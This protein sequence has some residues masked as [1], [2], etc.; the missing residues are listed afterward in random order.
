MF[1]YDIFSF[2]TTIISV[3]D[4]SNGNKQT[5]A[6]EEE[7]H[8]KST[9]QSNSAFISCSQLPSIVQHLFPLLSRSVIA[10]I[11]SELIVIGLGGVLDK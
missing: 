8:R 11:S 5:T 2:F 10:L 9:I 7:Y 6:M 1:P 4:F 3:S